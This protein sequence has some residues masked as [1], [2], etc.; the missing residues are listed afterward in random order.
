MFRE[1]TRKHKQIPEAECLELLQNETR[2]VL[3][4]LGDDDYPYG[5]PMNHF[6]NPDDGCIYFH[7]GRQRSHRNDALRRHPR[8]SFC[9]VEK[10]VKEEGQ[11]AFT[12]RSLI[13]FGRVEI[14]D[15]R[16]A[17]ADI[18]ARLSR[19]FTRDEAYI[20]HEIEKSGPAT[21]LLKLI[22]EHITGKRIV[23]S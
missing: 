23:E 13:V 17:V 11:W 6:Y 15:D 9:V 3:C 21:L 22:P 7:C 20:R 2:G 19:K 14:M 8:A 10:G 1:M 18:S 12:V 4:V 16:D 5:M